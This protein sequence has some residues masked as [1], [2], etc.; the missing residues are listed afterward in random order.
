MKKI[1]LTIIVTILLV[2]CNSNPSSFSEREVTTNPDSKQKVLHT[3]KSKTAADYDYHIPRFTSFDYLGNDPSRG[4]SSYVDGPQGLA[5]DGAHWFLANKEKIFKWDGSYG[6]PAYAPVGSQ[7]TEMPSAVSSYDHFGDLDYEEDQDL[8][9]VPLERNDKSLA[10]RLVVFDAN[11]NYIDSDVLDKNDTSTNETPWVSIDPV[12]KEIYTSKFDN[13]S[14]LWIYEDLDNSSG[15]DLDYI[16]SLSLKETNGTSLVLHGVQGGEFSKSGHLFLFAQDG[17]EG[18]GIYVIN[19]QNGRLLNYKYV[20]YESGKRQEFEGIT[21]WDLDNEPN[22]GG[23]EGQV[24]A[25]VWQD[26]G[27]FRGAKYWLKHYRV[28]PSTETLYPIIYAQ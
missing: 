20:Q 13:V 19:I 15:L 27:L 9:Y 22:S 4:E 28:H 18:M 7:Y 26:G 12:S 21:I 2:G 14:E 3:A 5:N 17:P 25:L 23:F 16:R 1:L 24:H 6:F 8:L 11:L 10:P